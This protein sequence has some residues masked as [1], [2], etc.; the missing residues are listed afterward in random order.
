MTICLYKQKKL[1]RKK[2]EF[3]FYPQYF[4]GVNSST[5]TSSWVLDIDVPTINLLLRKY[6]QH[7]KLLHRMICM[8][9]RRA[10]HFDLQVGD[11]Q[12][13]RSGTC[14]VGCGLR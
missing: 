6:A 12:E 14:G 8:I 7:T 5:F 11:R 9:S 1:A 2:N 13:A 3:D 4:L 10:S